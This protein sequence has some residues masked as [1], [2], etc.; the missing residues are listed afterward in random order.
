MGSTPISRPILRKTYNFVVIGYF[1][2]SFSD[3]VS[4]YQ[5]KFACHYA[6]G[7]SRKAQVRTCTSRRSRKTQEL[8]G[9]T[10]TWPSSLQIVGYEAAQCLCSAHKVLFAG[11][12]IGIAIQ[13]RHKAIDHFYIHPQKVK[14]KYHKK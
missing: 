8:M 9:R 3:C 13:I 10:I 7:N 6:I 4:H 1:F 14:M 11:F 12:V 5:L 2:A